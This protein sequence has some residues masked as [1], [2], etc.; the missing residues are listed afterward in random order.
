MS[1]TIYQIALFSGLVWAAIV[2]PAHADSEADLP[3]LTLGA[4]EDI[5]R[6]ADPLVNRFQRLAEA[7]RQGAVADGQLPDP[8]LKLG[9]ANFPT[10]NFNRTEEPMTQIKVGVIQAF[11]RGDTLAYKEKR[12]LALGDAEQARSEDQ[13]LKTLRGT[14]EAWLEVYF[15]AQAQ[16]I[17][18]SSR[19]FF[20]QLVG[21][22]EAQYGAGRSNQQ[23][24][25][26]AGLEL[27]RLDDRQ[28]RIQTAE[29]TARAELAKWVGEAALQPLPD[30]LP[31]LPRVRS[32]G[33]LEAAIPDHPSIAV[34][35]A[36]VVANRMNERVAREQYKPGWSLDVTYG[37]RGGNHPDGEDR[38]DF[39]SAMVVMDMP[40][41]TG[42]RQ[43]RR[44]A[45]S[46]QER[47][48]ATHARDDRL[49]ELRRLL[50]SE[51][52]RWR[53]LGERM[54]LYEKRLIPESEANVEA[55]LLA[56]QSRVTE[57]ITLMR[58]RITDLDTRL[59]AL[60]LRVDRAKA[61]ARLLYVAGEK[62]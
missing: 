7:R 45:A 54:A 49:R 56:Y 53:R 6:R 25:L 9:L 17:V 40:L 48:A 38:P 55:A 34:E 36:R 59:Q 26:Q 14:R 20:V 37:Q 46:E 3:A 28:T 41:F 47:L 33:D 10:D 27:S 23:D 30:G 58:A 8:K 32:M 15:Q 1:R 35:N 18:Q 13:A 57:F 61:Q 44:L 12:T 5:A 52:A 43:D 4:A 31:D 19:E 22:T 39:L 62:T 16:R 24:V 60:R 50:H 51:Y 21:V 11:P 42:Q 2:L 29:D